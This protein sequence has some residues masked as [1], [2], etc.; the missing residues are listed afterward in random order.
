MTIAEQMTNKSPQIIFDDQSP[1]PEFAPKQLTI[2]VDYDETISAHSKAWLAVME[3][4]KGFGMKIYVV[5]YRYNNIQEELDLEYL[6]H[7]DFIDG[8][9]FTGRRGK[10]KFCQ[11]HG[12]HIDIWID[13]NPITITHTMK[14][15]DTGLFYSFVPD[16]MEVRLISPPKS[17]EQ[18]QYERTVIKNLD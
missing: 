13:D 7:Y 1:F 10:K 18:A 8:L 9:I 15:I 6:K 4:L 11:E 16:D 12:I 17:I 14:G 3:V 5:T 2:A